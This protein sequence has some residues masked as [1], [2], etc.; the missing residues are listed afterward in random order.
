[1]LQD[2]FF[3]LEGEGGLVGWEFVFNHE[4]YEL[5]ESFLGCYF[6]L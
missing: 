2:I 3:F 1:M 6:I 5:C 4:S